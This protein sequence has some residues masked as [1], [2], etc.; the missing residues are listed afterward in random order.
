MSFSGFFLDRRDQPAL[1]NRNRREM[2]FYIRLGD[3][4][5]AAQNYDDALDAY[6]KAA[7]LCARSKTRPYT[8]ALISRKIAFCYKMKVIVLQK[9]V[10]N[11]EIDDVLVNNFKEQNTYLK[12]ANNYLKSALDDFE[13]ND[14]IRNHET[15]Q[16]IINTIETCFSL[17]SCY[18]SQGKFD[19]VMQQA[20]KGL[21]LTKTLTFANNEPS[22]A[23]LKRELEGLHYLISCYQYFETPVN[24]IPY[25][26]RAI[27]INSELEKRGHQNS[28]ERLVLEHF[29][30]ETR[31]LEFS[32]TEFK[33][34][35]PS[36]KKQLHAFHKKPAIQT[37]SLITSYSLLG[38]FSSNPESNQGNQN[39]TKEAELSPSP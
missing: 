6:K 33:P 36:K 21:D 15:Q 23:D 7:D 11:E 13:N 14:R 30:E 16:K 20:L 28:S 32:E 25:Y 34:E 2:F 18:K 17:A 38:K 26:V 10:E 35:L 3:G 22:F 1:I 8:A 37:D 31:A 29:L 39:N 24:A 4:C 5:F 27:A 12:N 19:K 9:E